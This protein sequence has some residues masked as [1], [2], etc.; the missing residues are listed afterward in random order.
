ML[1]RAGAKDGDS[2]GLI[3]YPR[4][5]AG[6]DAV[7]LVRQ[8]DA[9]SY[10]FSLRSRGAIDVE[11]VARKFGGGG[12][13][14]AAGFTANGDRKVLFGEVLQS[15]TEALEPTEAVASSRA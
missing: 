11:Q 12:H 10:K 6:V 14:N 15:L 2:E 4:S 13:P 7:A 5:I 3:D 9:S 1:R 8:L